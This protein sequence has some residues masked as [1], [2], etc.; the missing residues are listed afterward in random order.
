MWSS[1]YGRVLDVK[2]LNLSLLPSRS[3][4]PMVNSHKLP[5][6]WSRELEDQE[7]NLLF[8]IGQGMYVLVLLR[9]RHWLLFRLML[10]LQLQVLH[11][12]TL[13]CLEIIQRKNLFT[14]EIQDFGLQSNVE[15]ALSFSR[16]GS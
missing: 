2:E 4:L 16:H 3:A 6:F 1:R 13:S 7:P 11:E 12:N 10:L 14:A 8:Q 9:S 5:T 15:V